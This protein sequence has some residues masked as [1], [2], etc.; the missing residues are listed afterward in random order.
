MV[1]AL[2]EGPLTLTLS[3]EGRGDDGGE[4]GARLE[5]EPLTRFAL[6]AIHPLPQGERGSKELING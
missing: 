5:A 3:P 2:V 4:C 1:L 6:C